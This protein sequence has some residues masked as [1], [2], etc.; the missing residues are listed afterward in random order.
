MLLDHNK[1]HVFSKFHILDLAFVAELADALLLIV[2]PQ[3][4]FFIVK[5]RVLTSAN[6]SQDIAS[7]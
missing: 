6:Q 1:D 2:V 4:D 3:E 5:F 7:K